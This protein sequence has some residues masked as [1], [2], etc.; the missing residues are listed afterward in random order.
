[1]TLKSHVSLWVTIATGLNVDIRTIDSLVVRSSSGLP[2]FTKDLPA[3]GKDLDRALSSGKLSVTAPFSLKTNSALPEF[4]YEFFI[5][6]FYKDGYIRANPTMIRETRQLLMLFYKFNMPFSVEDQ[7]VAYQKFKDTDNEVKETSW[8]ASIFR[9]RKN[10][11]ELFPNDPYDIKCCHTAGATADGFSNEMKIYRRRLIPS[12][13]KSY[14][15]SYFFNSIHH[16]TNW[17]NAS[18]I[19]DFSSTITEPSSKVTLVP[20]DSRGPRIICMEPH[21][22]MFVQRGLMAKL[23][24]HIENVSPARGHINFTDQRINRN[25]AQQGSIDQSWATIDLKDASDLVSN[26]LIQKLAPDEW[27]EPLAATRSS[28]T[29]IDHETLKLK[30]FAPMGSA[31]CFPIEAMLFYAISRTICDEV[32]V[33]GDDIIVPNAFA[34]DVMSALESYGLK[35]NHDKSLHTGLFRESCG[36]EYYNGES[37][38]YIKCKSYD[39]NSFTAMCNLITDSYGLKLSESVMT[40]YVD[41]YGRIPFKKPLEESKFAEPFVFYT[42][43]L[44]SN[45]VFFKRRWN[46]DLQIFE[47]RRLCEGVKRN[48]SKTRCDDDLLFN[49]YTLSETSVKPLEDRLYREN[50]DDPLSQSDFFSIKYS[51]FDPRDAKPIV[52]YSWGS[53][54]STLA[55][56]CHK[57]TL[58]SAKGTLRLT[59][60]R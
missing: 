9:V 55:N 40:W 34:L 35:V 16:Y 54:H 24:D 39:F 4:L 12:L 48:E 27:R 29:V 49:W 3:L 25:L 15:L 53:G 13:M 23:Y 18:N 32:Y 1:M 19:K 11:R 21:E 47:Y 50:F 20:K 58:C 59:S 41:T 5:K 52:K 7:K 26:E 60:K 33:Y 14:D 36:G 31:L 37:I 57:R 30:K 17:C 8:P 42:D 2:F 6:I 56:L 46:R 38:A 44:A 10:F 51:T 28:S 45:D 22:R 43:K